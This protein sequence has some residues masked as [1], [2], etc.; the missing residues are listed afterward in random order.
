[1]KR[2]KIKMGRYHSELMMILFPN[3][4]PIGIDLGNIEIKENKNQFHK[5]VLKPDDKLAEFFLFYDAQLMTYFIVNQVEMPKFKKKRSISTQQV[6]KIA[7][8]ETQDDESLINELATII[9]DDSFLP[10]I[11]SSV[12]STKGYINERLTCS[13]VQKTSFNESKTEESR[14]VNACQ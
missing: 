6:K 9:K 2:R 12:D 5:F 8:F 11:P 14:G 7:Y 10:W 13:E 3:Q 4:K 1:M